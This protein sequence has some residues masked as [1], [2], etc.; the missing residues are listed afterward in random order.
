MNKTRLVSQK[1]AKREFSLIGK[2]LLLYFLAVLYVPF[3]LELYLEERHIRIAPDLKSYALIFYVV[4]ISFLCF[5]FIKSALRFKVKDF[6]RPS[7]FGFRDFLLALLYTLALGGFLIF[8]LEIIG[9]Y[10]PL[11]RITLLPIGFKNIASNRYDPIIAINYVLITPLLSEFCFRGVLLRA[12]GRYGNT[13]ASLAIS[14]L[15][16]LAHASLR[17]AVVYFVLSYILCL[18]TIKYHDI[19]PA[20]IVHIV[21]NAWVYLLF[22]IITPAS[23]LSYILVAALYVL[24][25]ILFFLRFYPF[26]HLRWRHSFNLASSLFLRRPSIILVFIILVVYLIVGGFDAL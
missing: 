8:L 19:K 25:T 3:L 10:L 17:D 20:I 11:D 5:F 4:I 15:F 18:I 26:I 6:L 24:V 13:F 7:H 22:V 9:H 21:F 12:L 14:L 16:G 1:Q 23:L 2:G